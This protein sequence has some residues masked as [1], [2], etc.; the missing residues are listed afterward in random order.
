MEAMEKNV[1]IFWVG[2]SSF[3]DIDGRIKNI[4]VPDER[5][6]Q[7]LDNATKIAEVKYH[8]NFTESGKRFVSGLHFNE[9]NSFL[10]VTLV[11]MYQ[12]KAKGS[13]ITPYP[14][15]LGNISKD[16][17]LNNMKKKPD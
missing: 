1:I 4:L 17:T 15:Y 9:G 16:V 13:E 7:A 3:V 6:T 2:N 8:I 10:F 5:I 12:C 14:L 11:T